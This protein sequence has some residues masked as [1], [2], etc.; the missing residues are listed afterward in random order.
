MTVTATVDSIAEG[1][2]VLDSPQ[3]TLRVPAALLPAGTREGDKVTL[4]LARDEKATKAGRDEIG[5]IRKRM[6]GG[7]KSTDVTDL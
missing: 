4:S 6:T 7:K 1:V 5:D 2:A 3:G